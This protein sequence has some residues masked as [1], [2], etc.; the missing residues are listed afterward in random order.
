MVSLIPTPGGPGTSS[1]YERVVVGELFTNTSCPTCYQ[2]DTTLSRVLEDHRGSFAVIRYHT[3]FPS[4]SDP[5]YQ[6]NT[7]E[8][9]SRTNYYSLT[10]VPKLFLDGT[11]TDTSF[12]H[13]DSLV[14]AREQVPTSLEI[15]LEGIYD[16]STRQGTVYATITAASADLP[17]D[18]RLFSV[19]VED[20]I[21]WVAP[22]KIQW[23]N[24]VMRDMLPSAYGDTITIR[25]GQTVERSQAFTVRSEW[26]DLDCGVVVFVQNYATKQVIQGG[27]W[28]LP[29][30]CVTLAPE[31]TEVVRRGRL[32][33]DLLIRSNSNATQS[34]SYWAEVTMPNGRPY[35]GN[36]VVSPQPVTLPAFQTFGRHLQHTIPSTA[37]LGSYIYTVKAGTYPSPVIDSDHFHFTVTGTADEQTPATPA[38]GPIEQIRPLDPAWP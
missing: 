7:S 32:E 34:F 17:I 12:S 19:L 21:Y 15:K 14:T 26:S 9:T 33:Y 1:A 35:A 25:P 24:Q 30:V 11:G 31:T 28:P 2:A 20:S 38:L 10:Y 37:P 13:W 36:P 22:N 27:I 16:H 23:H 6:A 3:W 18:V 29:K 5:F 8:N 4:S